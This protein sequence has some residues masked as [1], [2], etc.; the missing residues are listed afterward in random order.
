MANPLNFDTLGQNFDKIWYKTYQNG[1]LC[2]VWAVFFPIYF[3]SSQL[4][5]TCCPYK[6]ILKQENKFILVLTLVPNVI[7]VY[8]KLQFPGFGQIHE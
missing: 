6:N 7:S 2:V 1:L 3:F 5:G 4:T 8:L